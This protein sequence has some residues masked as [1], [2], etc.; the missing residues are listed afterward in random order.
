MDIG[1]GCVTL[2]L[3]CDGNYDCFDKSHDY[4]SWYAMAK[5]ISLARTVTLIGPCLNNITMEVTEF[6]YCSCSE[7]LFGNVEMDDLYPI[8]ECD[9]DMTFCDDL[10]LS[11]TKGKIAGYRMDGIFRPL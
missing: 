6:W 2:D 4:M 9:T 1:Q 3:A 8:T 10:D 5:A 11:D 7:Y